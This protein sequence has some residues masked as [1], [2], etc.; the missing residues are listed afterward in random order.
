LEQAPLP[1]EDDLTG[2]AE[3]GEL[4]E[5]PF[6]ERA[7][8]AAE[9]ADVENLYGSRAAHARLP[10]RAWPFSLRLSTTRPSTSSSKRRTAAAIS[11]AHRVSSKAV[12]SATARSKSSKSSSWLAARWISPISAIRRAKRC[13]WLSTCSP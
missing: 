2:R 10:T 13:W 12:G 1:E 7:A 9:P 8:A 5:D 11:S 6:D 4:A 3:P